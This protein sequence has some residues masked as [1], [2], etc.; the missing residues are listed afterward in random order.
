MFKG[1]MRLN[2]MYNC[3]AFL[4]NGDVL[5]CIVTRTYLPY[6]VMH[7]EVSA[8]SAESKVSKW[9]HDIKSILVL[10]V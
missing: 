3:Y 1:S 6:L 8:L 4:C 5:V 10:K 9:R 2:Y 7:S